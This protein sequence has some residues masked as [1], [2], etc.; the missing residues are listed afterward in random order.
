M[1]IDANFTLN[2]SPR[3]KSS[4]KSSAEECNNAATFNFLAK[5][6]PI[7]S[8]PN[9]DGEQM[10]DQ[11][12]NF[13]IGQTKQSEGISASQS[14]LV[15]NEA[16]GGPGIEED[17]SETTTTFTIDPKGNLKQ[18]FAR[19]SIEKQPIVI[20]GSTATLEIAPPKM[21]TSS[22]GKSP[23]VKKRSSER[24]GR[25]LQMP[26]AWKQDPCN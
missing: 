1:S 2:V 8:D 17:N 22:T 11:E 7:D 26:T 9:I 20:S 21:A 16:N 12:A 14:N 23:L 4:D 18:Q 25:R 24:A 15:E 19:L 10:M 13:V 3:R 6:P 5:L